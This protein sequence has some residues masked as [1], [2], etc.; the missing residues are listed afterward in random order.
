M[1][2]ASDILPFFKQAG[3]NPSRK[4]TL[5]T[6]ILNLLPNNHPA[7]QILTQLS[8]LKVGHVG[9]GEQCATSDIAFGFIEDED[10]Q[11]SLWNNVL[12]TKLIGV[13]EFCR[14]HSELYVDSTGRFFSH[15]LRDTFCFEGDSFDCAM[16]NLLFGRRCRPML[17]PDQESVMVYG[18]ILTADSPEVYK[19]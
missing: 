10:E 2:I 8:G 7:F 17:L 18:N 11:I 4:I 15:H 9:E 19:Y 16:R 13:A 5:P 1:D 3:W 14:Q 12:K 6:K